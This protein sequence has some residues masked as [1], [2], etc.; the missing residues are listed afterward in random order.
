MEFWPG[1]TS[2]EGHPASMGVLIDRLEKIEEE[3][4]GLQRQI[5]EAMISEEN[6]R[7]I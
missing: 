6:C 5:R 2:E 1:W 7:G 3:K 4:E